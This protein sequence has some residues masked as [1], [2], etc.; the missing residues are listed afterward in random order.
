MTSKK[1]VTGKNKKLRQYKSEQV[2]ES[3]KISESLG[4]ESSPTTSELLH[5]I[6]TH[7]VVIF[8]LL[9]IFIFIFYG[10]TLNA[11]F[12]YDDLGQIQENTRI[13]SLEN[14]PSLFTKSVWSFLELDDKGIGLNNYYRPIQFL[15]YTITFYFAQLNPGAY[16]RVSVIFHLLDAILVFFVAYRLLES[17]I[18]GL[19]AGLLFA[20]HPVQTEVV[21]WVACQPEQLYTMCYLGGIL[22]YLRLHRGSSPWYRSP[23]Y[24]VIILLYYVGLFCKESM[25]TLPVFLI[26]IDLLKYRSQKWQSLILRLLPFGA[27]FMLYLPW[28][29]MALGGFAPFKRYSMLPWFQVFLTIP[30]LIRQYLQKMIYPIPLNAYYRFIPVFSFQDLRLWI[31]M[32]VILF[33][34]VTGYI[35]WNKKS[36]IPLI[37]MAWFLIALSPM[38]YIRGIGENVF[39]ERYLYLPSIGFILVIVSCLKLFFIHF[40]TKLMQTTLAIVLGLLFLG[41]GQAVRERNMDWHDKGTFM[42]SLGKSR[43]TTPGFLCHDKATYLVEQ[44]Q[45]VKDPKQRQEIY[46]QALQQFDECEK[47]FG[48]TPN[49]YFNRGVVYLELGE[50]DKAETELNKGFTGKKPDAG[51]YVM[52]GQLALKKQDPVTAKQ[53]FLKALEIDDHFPHAFAALARLA[54][55]NGYFDEALG[56]FLKL[57]AE[58]PNIASTKAEIGSTYLMKE[59]LDNAEK[60]CREAIELEPLFIPAYGNLGTIYNRRG[61]FDKARQMYE[62]VLQIDPNNMQAKMLIAKIDSMKQLPSN[63]QVPTP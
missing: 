27:A 38:L 13:R 2:P 40:N 54:N 28:R 15:V 50:L 51:V 21:S 11:E 8:C 29:F 47:T 9:T 58:I 30:D 6:I 5:K 60:Y 34:V 41:M 32:L 26:V 45:N 16:H 14:I 42:D 24:F 23:E 4:D 37:G 55:I 10:N 20:T 53:Q 62:K 35:F 3:N 61:E 19:V 48:A 33:I 7:P 39:C 22:L 36:V 52:L 59:D 44:A 46:Q 43:E 49:L 18:W 17:R 25:V 1:K 57:D 12:V 63:F 31:A 56:Y